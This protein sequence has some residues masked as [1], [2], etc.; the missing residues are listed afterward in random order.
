MT[1]RA[2]PSTSD[3]AAAPPAAGDALDATTQPA[4]SDDASEE[5][6]LTP[7]EMIEIALNCPCTEELRNGSCGEIFKEAYRC[8]LTV[9]LETAQSEEDDKNA[10]MAAVESDCG[11]KMMAMTRCL[12]EH[13]EEFPDMFD[14]EDDLAAAAQETQTTSE[15]SPSSSGS[16]GW[17]SAG[18]D[19]IVNAFSRLA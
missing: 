15:E 8:F 1:V 12:A 13:A 7:E 11:E 9:K 3:F 19:A 16:G 10:E 14:D 17:L 6:D 5:R 2:D 18:S 4:A